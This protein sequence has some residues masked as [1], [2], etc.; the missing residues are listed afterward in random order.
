MTATT[1]SAGPERPDAYELAAA[2]RGVELPDDGWTGGP[3]CGH[4]GG[5]CGP[6][7]ACG[8]Y[9]CWHAARSHECPRDAFLADPITMAYGVGAEMVGLINCPVCDAELDQ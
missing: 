7:C 3:P 2:E 6:E 9:E 5:P 1:T 8:C 4:G